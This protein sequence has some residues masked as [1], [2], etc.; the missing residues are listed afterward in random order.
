MDTFANMTRVS[1]VA[2]GPL[3]LLVIMTFLLAI[4]LKKVSLHTDIP[5]VDVRE[6]AT[7]DSQM[8]T[9]VLKSIPAPMQIQWSVQNES[10]GAWTPIDIN[11]EN[12]IGTRNSLPQPVLVVNRK[13]NIKPHSFQIEA[14]NFIGT[15]TKL[16]PGLLLLYLIFDIFLLEKYSSIL[17]IKK[18]TLKLYINIYVPLVEVIGM[19]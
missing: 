13:E 18:K 19:S 16:I 7:N 8:F 3:V 12:Y 17:D 4:D 14:K 11:T 5:A 15:K 1:N 6:S 2:P 10:T 9:A